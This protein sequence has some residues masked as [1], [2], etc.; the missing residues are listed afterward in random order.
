M[1]YFWID[2]V[3]GVAADVRDEQVFVRQ[4]FISGFGYASETGQGDNKGK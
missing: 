1:F 2:G 4:G 3:D